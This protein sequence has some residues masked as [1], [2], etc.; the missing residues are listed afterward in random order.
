MPIARWRRVFALDLRSLAL[1]RIALGLLLLLSLGER[2]RDVTAHYT[3]E[4][5]LSREARKT[6]APLEEFT[7]PQWQASLFMLSGEAWYVHT[8]FA[9]S[10]VLAVL[11]LVGWRTQWMVL[12]SWVLLVGVQGRN[13]LLLQGGDD[14]LRC[15][16]F[17]SIFVPLGARW[18]LDARRQASACHW[19]LVRQCL[20]EPLGSTGSKLPVAHLGSKLPVP[21]SVCTLG[22]A[23]LILQLV[24]IYFFT[25]LLKDH[26]IWRTQWSAVYYTLSIDHF[27]T[28][29]GR[30]LLQFP[31]LLQGLT[32]GA[33]VLELVGPLLLLCS[34]KNDW[35]RLGVVGGFVSFH[36]GLAVTM[37]LG[38]FPYICIAYWLV[39]LPG[40][41]WEF[42]GSIATRSASESSK[43]V[44]EPSPTLRV[45]KPTCSARVSNPAGAARISWAGNCLLAVLL[46]YVLLLNVARVS[47]SLAA[48]LAG[49]P[50]RIAGD[51]AQL[52]QFWC[53]FAPKPNVYGGWLE[54][55]GELADGRRVNLLRPEQPAFD[56]RPAVVSSS[57]PSERWRKCLMN[58]FERGELHDHR[59]RVGD[60]FVRRWNA[61][62]TSGRR[63]VSAE[64]VNHVRP[65]PPPG[66]ATVTQ[67]ATAHVLWRWSAGGEVRE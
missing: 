56:E 28:P 45:M 60:Y 35:L 30:W 48:Q 19:L 57:Y 47:G 37:E 20:Q 44:I 43:E 27:A 16:V 13:P 24:C 3:D 12:G 46:A 65:T 14:V 26:P 32:L 1:L 50:V 6:L 58:L 31:T 59:Q 4:G 41:F 10:A 11:L 39:L 55:T 66:V 34:W 61:A 53:M 5:I 7:A 63:L 8:L 54:L 64:I 15:L 51:A 9:A 22:T 29:L 52:N 49:G 2:W 17:W 62:A 23:A 21:P 40:R 38:F 67:A 25:G 36:L 18:S 42:L 33:L